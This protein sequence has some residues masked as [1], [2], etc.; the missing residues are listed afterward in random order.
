MDANQYYPFRLLYTNAQGFGRFDM[1]LRDPD[2]QVVLEHN[3]TANPFLVTCPSP[4]EGTWDGWGFE[5]N[6][7]VFDLPQAP[8]VPT[9]KPNANDR[10]KPEDKKHEDKKPDKT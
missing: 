6:E 8:L 4:A 5:N 7:P 2:G 3:S 9:G 1:K 10:K